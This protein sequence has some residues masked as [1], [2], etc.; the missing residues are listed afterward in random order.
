MLNNV[1]SSRDKVRIHRE[2][3]RA[4]GLRPVQIW[5]PDVRARS[6]VRAAHQQS[7]AV[8]NSKRAKGDQ[9]FIDATSDN[10]AE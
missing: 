1:R 6:F 7:M 9:E 5:V 8:A 2:R 10:A 4:Q 3:L